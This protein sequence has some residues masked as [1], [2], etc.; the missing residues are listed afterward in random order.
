MEKH[1][2]KILDDAVD[3]FASLPGIGRKTALRL[4]LHCIYQDPSV[5][6][7]FARSVSKLGTELK[8]CRKC[9]HV[10]DADICHIC[11][12]QKRD[13]NTICIV[14]SIRDVMA[15]EDTG[16]FRGLY[17]VLG[18]IISPIDGIGPDDLNIE[19]LIDRCK[20]DKIDE[21]IMGISPTI[22]GETTIYYL[23]RCLNDAGVHKISI[24]AR[25]VAFG[26]EL[27]YADE[28][29]LGRSIRARIPYQLNE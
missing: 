16:H 29:T 11:T 10:S 27:E 12:D 21:V 22:D 25:G 20:K 2:S 14:E 19:T 9:H 15:I 6:N 26:G 4:A 5:L 17:H 1:S 8:F 28:M 18:G 13:H 23:T 24:L 3:A 7:N